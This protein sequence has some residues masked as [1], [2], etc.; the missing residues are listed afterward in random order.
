MFVEGSRLFTHKRAL[1][2]GAIFLAVIP[3]LIFFSIYVQIIPFSR[4]AVLW[5]IVCSFGSAT[6]FCL[7]SAVTRFDKIL[8]GLQRDV[9]SAKISGLFSSTLTCE[10]LSQGKF[11]LKGI[12][13]ERYTPRSGTP[14]YLLWITTNKSLPRRGEIFKK[15]DRLLRKSPEVEVSVDFKDKLPIKKLMAFKWLRS[16]AT[17]SGK[18]GTKLIAKID[19]TSEASEIMECLKI[20]RELEK[21]L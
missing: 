17:E 5:M 7:R 8:N 10:T 19:R 3:V 9:L 6:C 14:R 11:S 2:I 1:L 15:K 20:L 16:I 13:D 12:I 21:K 18:N 4:V